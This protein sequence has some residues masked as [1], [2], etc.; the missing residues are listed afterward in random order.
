MT[1]GIQSLYSSVNHKVGFTNY[2]DGINQSSY[3]FTVAEIAKNHQG[4]LVSLITDAGELDNIRD[5]IEYFLSGE[6]IPVVTFPDWETLPY[7]YF[8]P[9]QDIISQRL[10]ALYHLPQ[11]HKGVLLLPVTSALQKLSDKSFIQL[12]CHE[13]ITGKQLQLT[14]LR[15]QLVENGYNQVDNVVTH[16]EFA[17]RGSIVDLYPSSL[18]EPVRI[19]LFDD[20]IESLRLFNPDSQLST[21][22][23]EQFSLLPA[24]EFPVDEAAISLFRQQWRAKFD[25]NIREASIYNEVSQGHF[26]PG[27]EYYLPLFFKQT[28]HIFDFISHQDCLLV[29]EQN[30]QQTINDYWQEL[31]ERHEQYRH[32]TDRPI[33][34]PDLLFLKPEELNQHLKQFVQVHIN[35]SSDSSFVPHA[36]KTINSALK[37]LSNIQTDAKNNQFLNLKT[38][39]ADADKTLICA[40]SHGRQQV[41]QELI[42]KQG[43]KTVAVNSWKDF[44]QQ[45]QGVY[46]TVAPLVKG[47]AFDDCQIITESDLF[48][49]HVLQRKQE[50]TAANLSP[51][52]LIHSLAELKI[53]D[54]VVHIH[55]GVG[56][57]LGLETLAS[58]GFE[59]DYLTLEYAGG[60]K[61]YVPAQSLSMIHRYAGSSPETAPWHKLGSDSWKKSKE[62]AVKQARDTAAELLDLYAKRNAVKGVAHSCEHDEYLTF[63]NQFEYEPTPD[64]HTVFKAVYEDMTNP[65][66]MDRLVCGDVGFGKTEVAM[67][68]AFIAVQSGFQVA[69]L[70]P[71]TLLAQQHH[72]S[73][74]N[75]FAN[76]PVKIEV[77]SRFQSKKQQTAT[78][79]SLGNGQTD[80]VIATH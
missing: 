63:T 41:L 42:I 58:G 72:E 40:D 6:N 57:Y 76:W 2:I 30:I 38:M 24:R 43:V 55:Q 4:L 68:A 33:L 75:R 64:Q 47:F 49:H 35:R 12:N 51:D 7:D 31:A 66:P 69:I 54:P 52:Q 80:I 10:R 65:R 9:H 71:T 15:K 62:K 11:M 23:I 79:E 44:E 34:E 28:S 77:L 13:F 32:D 59:N 21:Q 20:E 17:V 70:V 8:S 45:N 18:N 56:R 36:D 39:I 37:A 73:F 74:T 14:Q 16:G 53:G 46:L 29:T 3:S 78:E 67:R 48:G 50:A 61:L 27:I 1:N 25:V 19:E 26:P 60:D 5:E 22:K